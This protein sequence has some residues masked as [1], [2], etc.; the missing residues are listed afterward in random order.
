MHIVRLETL[1]SAK[2]NALRQQLALVARDYVQLGMIVMGKRISSQLREFRSR[3]IC[4][5][6]H[7]HGYGLR[8][9]GGS[10][11]IVGRGASGSPG[12]V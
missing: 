1:S 8:I 5:G 10:L 12:S 6:A 2:L 11:R 4:I 9:M 7:R 3:C